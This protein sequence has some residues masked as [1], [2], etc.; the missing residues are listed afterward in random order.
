MTLAALADPLKTIVVIGGG[1]WGHLHTS[2]LL[3]AR[4]QGK[5]AF[6]RL[7]V[8][9]RHADHQT[10]RAF[11]DRPGVEF[12]VSDWDAFLS[13]FVAAEHQPGDLL[14]PAPIAPHLLFNWL[15][16]H[17]TR[18]GPVSIERELVTGPLETPF[19]MLGAHGERFTSFA[20]WRCPASCLEPS[21]CPAIRAPR[22]W[23]MVDHLQGLGSGLHSREI[24][25]ARHHAWGVAT[26]PIDALV[27]AATRLAKLI[28]ERTVTTHWIATVSACHGVVGQFTA[29][30]NV[31]DA[32]ASE[33]VRR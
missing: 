12:A 20:E 18:S 26:I 24:F 10:A 27:A 16:A 17:L 8:V 3:S 2:R 22:T 11:G 19:D 6:S 32:L 4:Q 21:V 29:R 14:V 1:C 25:V 5:T 7:L 33:E 23:E 28:A 13:R 15:I 31:C 9:D 30:S